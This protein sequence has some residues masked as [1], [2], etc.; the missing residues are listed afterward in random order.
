MKKFKYYAVKILIQ[1]NS[2]HYKTGDIITTVISSKH[3]LPYIHKKLVNNIWIG[4]EY[5]DYIIIEIEE[6]ES[7]NCLFS[8]KII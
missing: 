6:I 7:D 3:N 4:G 2:F 5:P 8:Y 1:S